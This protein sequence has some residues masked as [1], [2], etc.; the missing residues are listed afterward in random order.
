MNNVGN[1]VPGAAYR[2]SKLLHPFN[3]R[4][5]SV[6]VRGHKFHIIPAGESEMSVTVF[7]GD[8]TEVPY[9]IDAHQSGGTH[10][11][12]KY[13][14]TALGNMPDDPGFQDLMVFPVSII[15]CDNFRQHFFKIRGANICL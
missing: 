7:V 13:L 5:D 11:H 8:V 1:T 12:R 6:L 14:V 4:L 15:L 9:K 3:E 2:Q 10:P